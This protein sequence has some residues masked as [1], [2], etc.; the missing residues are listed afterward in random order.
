[1][2]LAR[3]AL[4]AGADGLIVECHA[5]PGRARSDGPQAL[6]LDETA[7]LARAVQKLAPALGRRAPQVNFGTVIPKSCQATTTITTSAPRSSV[8]PRS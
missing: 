3:A 6:T 1:L 8:S 5:E 7:E 4:A 2:P